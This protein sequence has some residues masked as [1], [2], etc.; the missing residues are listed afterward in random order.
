MNMH[1]RSLRINAALVDI[2]TKEE[3]TALIMAARQ[4]YVV[5]SEGSLGQPQE[6]GDV[7]MALAGMWE[8]LKPYE[9]VE[10]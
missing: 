7:D 9:D 2:S 10:V 6:A 8:A 3:K 1:E 4:L 5:S